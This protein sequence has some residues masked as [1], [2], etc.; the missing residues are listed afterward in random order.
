MSKEIWKPIWGYTGRYEVSTKGRVKSIRKFKDG[1]KKEII[2]KPDLSGNGYYYVSLCKN[3]KV[4]KA[5]INRLVAKA[6]LKNT[7]HRFRIVDHIN[8][9]KLD[10]RVENLRY[11]THRQNLKYAKENGVRFGR[12]PTIKNI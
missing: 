1:T 10:N 12:K 8:G 6:F 9:N 3:G 2:L 11:V 7:V 4:Y 5:G